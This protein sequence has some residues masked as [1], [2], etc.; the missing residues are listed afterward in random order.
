LAAHPDLIPILREEI[1]RVVAEEGM[2]K[3]AMQKMVKLDSFFREASR[4][5]SIV[6]G[7]SLPLPITPYLSVIIR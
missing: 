1:D 6:G 2:T 7:Q 4:M 3:S 5:D